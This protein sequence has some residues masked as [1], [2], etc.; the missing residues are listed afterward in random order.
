MAAAVLK[1]AAGRGREH[2][3]RAKTKRGGQRWWPEQWA[4]PGSRTAPET[5]TS[6]RNTRPGKP[7]SLLLEGLRR[8]QQPQRGPH[9]HKTHFHRHSSSRGSSPTT[10][11]RQPDSATSQ[12]LHTPPL[13]VQ[14]FLGVCV[15][16]PRLGPHLAQ[17][18][19]HALQCRLGSQLQLRAAEGRQ[20]TRYGQRG[21]RRVEQQGE[22]GIICE[23]LVDQSLSPRL[24]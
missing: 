4:V 18:L 19:L 16:Q 24:C 15:Q 3:Q 9:N 22:R 2:L 13:T 20:G 23:A 21:V 12:R 14:C 6:S 1:C 17:Q 10:G 7:C 8:V 5:Q 11:K